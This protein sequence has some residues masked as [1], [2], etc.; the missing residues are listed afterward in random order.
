MVVR[1]LAQDGSLVCGALDGGLDV[2]VILLDIQMKEMNGD[3]LCRALRSRG[4]RRPI[5][6]VTGATNAGVCPAAM[7][8]VG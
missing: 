8:S 2:D 3:V 4:D 1:L 5:I 7:V 6:A